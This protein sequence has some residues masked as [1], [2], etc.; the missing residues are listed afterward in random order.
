MK[1]IFRER[2]TL[3]R[4]T[5]TFNVDT[6]L[7]YLLTLRKPEDTGIKELSFRLATILCILSGQRSQTIGYLSL[8]SMYYSGQKIVFP[9][10]DLLKQTR[11]GFHQQP[12][13]FSACEKNINL[14]PVHN[15]KVYIEKTKLVR[16][17]QTFFYYKLC[18]TT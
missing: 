18:A 6:N 3:P 2:P 15:I 13:E 17:D 12:L 14:C 11:P 4:Y 8:Q 5:K 1:G 7:S 16:G 9:I 10:S